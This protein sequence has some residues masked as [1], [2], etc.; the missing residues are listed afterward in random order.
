MYHIEAKFFSRFLNE[1]IIGAHNIPK[2]EPYI[3]VASHV[4]DLDPWKLARAFL[5]TKIRF[6]T[7]KELCFWTD[8]YKDLRVRKQRSILYSLF[9]TVITIWLVRGGEVIPVDRDDKTPGLNIGAFNESVKILKAGGVIGIFPRAGWYDPMES[10]IGFLLLARK[11]KVPIVRVCIT[12]DSK[13]IIMK[14]LQLD[15][16]QISSR[17]Y[18]EL[19]ES[20]MCEVEALAA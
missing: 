12:K 6:W 7:K 4:G 14:P 1:T 10:Q 20:I 3:I 13:I 15:F 16:K 5:G 9:R 11:T 2:D 19:A 18:S 17:D 8:C